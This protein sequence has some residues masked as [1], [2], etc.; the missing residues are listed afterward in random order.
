MSAVCRKQTHCWLIKKY[1]IYIFIYASI[2]SVQRLNTCLVVKCAHLYLS[3][4]FLL[5]NILAWFTLPTWELSSTETK[6]VFV[7]V[8]QTEREKETWRPRF[9]STSPY[10]PHYSSGMPRVLASDNNKK[11]ELFVLNLP[12]GEVQ[13]NTKEKNLQ[14][15]RWNPGLFENE[16]ARFCI[17]QSFKHNHIK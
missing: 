13:E 5:L 16:L 14:L 11:I 3:F 8:R 1:I 4:F 12:Y 6:W 2:L 17:W 7:E 10:F 9:V 15:S